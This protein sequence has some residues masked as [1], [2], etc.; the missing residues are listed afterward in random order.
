[1]QAP[2]GRVDIAP[3]HS[4]PRYLMGWVVIVK[5]QPHFTP[6]KGP[7]V[8]I[9]REAGWASE[10]VWTQRQEEKYF[11]SDGDRTP[12]V[13]HCT[14]WAIPVNIREL[15]DSNI[16]P[17]TGYPDRGLSLLTS[18]PPGN[19]QKRNILLPVPVAAWSEAWSLRTWLRT[20]L[21]AWT[22]VLF[23]SSSLTCHPIIDAI[24]FSYWES[25]VK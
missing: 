16:D 12:I 11:V 8:S 21:E 19:F 7:S 23:Y 9:G 14:D 22:F 4:W 18:V 5:P 13:R 15:P 20:P 24:V 17:H 25:V 3:T 2:K 10:V 1:M 6:G